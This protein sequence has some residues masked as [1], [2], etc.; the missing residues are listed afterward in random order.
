VTD[1]GGC[2]EGGNTKNQPTK[3]SAEADCI[4]VGLG[5][6]DAEVVKF[7]QNDT[8]HFK[9]P[10]TGW[11]TVSIEKDSPLFKDIPNQAEFYFVH[12]YYIKSNDQKDVLNYTEYGQ[13]FVSSLSK[14]N[15]FGVQYHPEKS[16]D[17][18]MQ[19]LKNF[20]EL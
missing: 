15:I 1:E 14:D 10:H 20:V 7:Q 11:N 13:R 12:S 16:H 19:I 18:G 6:F 9:T 4:E 17:V 3:W 8:L 5:W 2:I